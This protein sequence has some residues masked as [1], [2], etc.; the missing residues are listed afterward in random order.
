MRILLKSADKQTNITEISTNIVW[1]GDDQQVARKV[2]FD[3]VVS[4]KDPNLPRVEVSLGN[5]IYLYNDDEE[6]LFRGYIFK[7]DSSSQSNKMKI[8]AYDGSIYLLRNEG[9]YNFKELPAESIAQKVCDD[10]SI[11]VG[12][13]ASTG[14][15]QSF[16]VVGDNLHDIIMKAYN[17]VTEETGTEYKLIFMEGKLNVIEKGQE[18]VITKLKSDED[19]TD[20]SYSESLDGLV[21]KV[22]IVDK[23]NNKIGEVED[24]DWIQS[25]GQFQKVY[26]EEPEK[27]NQLIAKN[28]L[29]GIEQSGSLEV[30]EDNRLISGNKIEVVDES[31][32]VVGEFMI[33]R[34]S[35]SWSDGIGKVSIDLKFIRAKPHKINSKFVDN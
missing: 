27:D 23:N 32:G 25:Y 4:N 6:E 19:I 33:E 16:V 22:I 34:D 8:I 7:K 31:L 15:N 14:I 26:K 20:S 29:Q 12:Q 18:G 35:H 5:M 3:L 30:R 28:M 1:E 9:S 24:S 21:N 11:Q 2:S 13:L 10:F 17:K